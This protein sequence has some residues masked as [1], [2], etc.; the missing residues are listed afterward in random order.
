MFI[1]Y[2]L[3]YSLRKTHDIFFLP[4]ANAVDL[5]P[6]QPVIVPKPLSKA[7]LNESEKIET[8]DKMTAV[9]VFHLQ[10]GYKP[11]TIDTFYTDMV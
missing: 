6:E 8:Q 1:F 11:K 7:S 3:L 4:L 2:I 5:V 9:V 10:E